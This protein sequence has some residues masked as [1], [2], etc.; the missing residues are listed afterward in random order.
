MKTNI[1]KILASLPKTIYFNLL[2]LPFR[3]AIRLPFFIYYNVRL[4]DI[5]GSQLKIN[6]SP[7]TFMIKYGLGGVKGIDSNRSQLW[8]QGGTVS[9]NG[10]A[11]FG[12]GFSIRCNGNLTFGD[13][14]GGG[15]NGFIS[16][17]DEISFGD[18]ILFAW[19]GTIRDSDGHTI[20][21]DGHEKPSHKPVHIGNH[22]WIASEVKILKGVSIA[23][24]CVI[25]LG[26]IV[27]K[28]FDEENILIGGFPAKKIQENVSWKS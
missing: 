7:K 21:V 4:G 11:N 25:A 19:N 18:D 24:G 6:C 27:T 15:K 26:S 14:F 16:C 22:V 8:L 5:S 9:F 17:A 2:C 13:N 20:Y 3:Q 23:D 28:S 12:E 10:R 1:F